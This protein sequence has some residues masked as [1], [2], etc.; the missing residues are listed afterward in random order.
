MIF[1]IYTPYYR[2]RDLCKDNQNQR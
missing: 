1:F 2:F